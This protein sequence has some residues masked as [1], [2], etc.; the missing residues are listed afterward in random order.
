MIGPSPRARRVG[1]TVDLASQKLYMASLNKNRFRASL[2]F[3]E[4]EAGLQDALQE[5]AQMSEVKFQ[6]MQAEQDEKDRQLELTL[7]RL[8]RAEETISR[9]TD[10]FT[11]NEAND[12]AFYCSPAQLSEAKF[13]AIKAEQDEK[14]RQ[15][16]LTLARLERAEE[17]ISRLT[18]RLADN[19]AKQTALASSTQA[20]VALYAQQMGEMRGMVARLRERVRAD[21]AAAPPKR[22]A[23]G[24]AGEGT[25]G[26]AATDAVGPGTDTGAGTA[27][28]DADAVRQELAAH[29]KAQLTSVAK[30]MQAAS[31]LDAMISSVQTLAAKQRAGE[32]GGQDGVM[33]SGDSSA[34]AIEL[35][36]KI[37]ALSN[38]SLLVGRGIT[39]PNV[40][41]HPVQAKGSPQQ[42]LASAG[43]KLSQL[44]ALVMHLEG[45]VRQHHGACMA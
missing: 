39:S 22:G 5:H 28:G 20:Q 38:C 35:S 23:L 17:T 21:A 29:R 8:E 14:D 44:S 7:A 2:S 16:E 34:V 9:L 26:A 40:D 27:S 18:D 45:V 36:R 6:A 10:R 42:R 30:V 13:Q 24:A 11:D 31:K 25:T 32:R 19:E 4:F 3:Q 41:S 37:D 12:M 43:D 15:L 1:Y 33:A